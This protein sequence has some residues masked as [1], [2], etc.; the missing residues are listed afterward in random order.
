FIVGFCG[1]TE[2]DFQQTYELVKESRFKNSF[3]FK[4]SERPGTK[5]AE[6]YA[7][8]VPFEVKNRRNNELL[9]LQNR[10]SEQDNQQFLGRRVEVLVEGASDRAKSR[11]EDAGE[12]VQLM[13]R[14]PDD[15]IVVFDGQPRLIGQIIPL[16]IYDVAA[17]TL[18]GAVVTEHVGPP[19]SVLA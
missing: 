16:A 8:D 9:E 14:T 11:G 3:I 18:F 2:A 6:L 1:E 13:G 7:D 15:R 17:H 5:G 10:L 4:Y 12:S 19:L